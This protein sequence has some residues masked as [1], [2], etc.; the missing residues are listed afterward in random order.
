MLIEGVAILLSAGIFGVYGLIH[1]LRNWARPSTPSQ[2]LG[3]LVVYV[4]LGYV[5]WFL[6]VMGVGTANTAACLEYGSVLAPVGNVYA[7]WQYSTLLACVL[8][9][10]VFGFLFVTK[11]TGATLRGLA[12]LGFM[13]SAGLV[14]VCTNVLLWWLISFELLLLVSLYLLR[15][16]SK[17]E[18]IG[19]AVAE[20]FF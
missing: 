3:A 9:S 1:G 12:G 11:L 13:L 18:R 8:P 16:T 14:F 15:L 17:S 6:C 2:V 10:V 7:G 19:E 4:L 5:A 20:M